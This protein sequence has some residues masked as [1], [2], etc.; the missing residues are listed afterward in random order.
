MKVWVR[1]CGDIR[2]IWDISEC[3]RL[4]CG[5]GY[6]GCRYS[7][8]SDIWD[9]KMERDI[10]REIVGSGHTRDSWTSLNEA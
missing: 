6:Y 7:V 9:G 1:S 3:R 2:S 4:I 5:Y 10:G 8:S